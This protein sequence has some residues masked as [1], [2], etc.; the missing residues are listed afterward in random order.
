MAYGAGKDAAFAI[1][2]ATGTLTHI[3]AYITS[4]TAPSIDAQIAEVS[5]LGDSYKE[6]IRTQV[7][8][9]K[10][11][12]E[13]IYDPLMGTLLFNLGT[14]AA[15]AFEFYPQGTASGKMKVSGSALLTSHETPAGIDD[16][17]TWK[18]D[19]QVTGAITMA[20]V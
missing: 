14:A 3:T 10:I 12:A 18:A 17:V 2:N 5:T 8:P 6:Y 20:T 16:A 9:G 15:G 1:T 4:I 7:D 19:W 11:S 13:G